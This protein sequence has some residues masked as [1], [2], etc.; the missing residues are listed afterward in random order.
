MYIYNIL[1][2]LEI[3]L[4]GFVCALSFNRAMTLKEVG[5]AIVYGI[6]GPIITAYMFVI[7]V[8]TFIFNHDKVSKRYTNKTEEKIVT[9][10]LTIYGFYLEWTLV[11]PF[12]G[13]ILL[14]T[15]PN[16]PQFIGAIIGGII[17]MVI[18]NTIIGCGIVYIHFL[19]YKAWF[20][21]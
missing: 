17:P 10:I 7:Y 5:L 14:N 9:V 12:M 19:N 4:V 3:L 21:R 8:Y 2:I 6:T 1:V 18:H 11:I 13:D 15:I 16:F 20:I